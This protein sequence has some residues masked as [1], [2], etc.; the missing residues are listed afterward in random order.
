M[1]EKEIRQAFPNLEIYE[2]ELGLFDFYFSDKKY[3]YDGLLPI[4]MNTLESDEEVLYVFGCNLRVTSK[5]YTYSPALFAVT[6]KYIL[7]SAF[8]IKIMESDTLRIKISDIL[9]LKRAFLGSYEIMT[10]NSRDRNLASLMPAGP[11]AVFIKIIHKLNHYIK[12]A[13]RLE[14]ES[15][16][17]AKK[18]EQESLRKEQINK[19]STI[20]DSSKK[21]GSYPEIDLSLQRIKS[22]D[23]RNQLLALYRELVTS[24][25]AHFFRNRDYDLNGIMYPEIIQYFTIIETDKILIENGMRD[26]GLYEISRSTHGVIDLGEYFYAFDESDNLLMLKPPYRHLSTDTGN[27]IVFDSQLYQKNEVIVIPKSE[28]VSYKLYGTELM[29]ST[30]RTN[31]RDNIVEASNDVSNPQYRSPSI[32]GTALS[33][34]LFGSA[35]TILNGV[36]KAMHQQTNVLGNK[37]DNLG[38]KLDD[39]VHAI[40]SISISTDHQIIDTSRVQIILTN[41]R[42]LE[43]DGV[44]I[45]YD[46]N[47]VYPNLGTEGS[48][49]QSQIG[50]MPI[51]QPISMTDEIMKLKQMFDDGIIDEEEFKAMKKKLI[52]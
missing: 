37:L 5:S 32:I 33:G 1:T 12:D 47:R 31:Q 22:F 14:E 34:F 7:V 29:Q 45:Y 26:Y 30:V 6:S 15:R 13:R 42:D 43:I 10:D 46:L 16:Q 4:L 35:Y 11:K 49:K 19:F 8:V 25:K 40:N 24:R 38:D 20:Y 51:A 23:I 44:N 50:S 39:V 36:G 9:E 2:N 41:R 48:V 17:N 21:E 28:I 3:A 27:Y 18:I 52:G